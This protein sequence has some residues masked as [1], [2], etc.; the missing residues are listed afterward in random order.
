M[1]EEDALTVTNEEEY[2]MRKLYSI[3]ILR[4]LNSTKTGIPHDQN[5]SI[6]VPNMQ[7]T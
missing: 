5:M 2:N 6:F 7:S 4:N 1:K 3:D